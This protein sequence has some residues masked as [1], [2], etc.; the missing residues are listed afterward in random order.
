[1]IEARIC[2][3]G[4][5]LMGGSLAQ[6]LRGQTLATIGVDA[7]A[8]TRQQALADGTV[9]FATDDMATGVSTADLVILATPVHSI[10]D[11]LALLPQIRPA[12]CMVLDFGST[13]QAI[14]A[15]MS[16]LPETFSAIGGHPMCGKETAGYQSADARLFEGQT[17]V[18][19]RN[20]RTTTAVE[21]QVLNLLDQLGAQ[22]LFLE[23][24]QHDELVAAVSHLPYLLAAMLMR[25]AASRNDE[26][27]WQISASGFRDTSR[28]AGSDPRMML[29][30]LLTNKT[31]VL[32]ELATYRNTLDQLVALLHEGDEQALVTWLAEAQQGHVAYRRHKDSPTP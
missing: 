5:G 27:V 12:G 16:A 1:M 17:F 25:Q 26:K 24:A 22:P 18:L 11:A 7:H 19:T 14:N 2:I 6:A 29:D 30:I 23:A 9:D 20:E 15:A 4:L 32:A 28:L 21:A 10:L 13:K 3:V 31:A 8:A